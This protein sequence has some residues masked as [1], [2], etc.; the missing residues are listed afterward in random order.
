METP[1]SKDNNER[2]RRLIVGYWNYSQCDAEDMRINS[3]FQG[4]S[5]AFVR[6]LSGKSPWILREA[7]AVIRYLAAQL[8]IPFERVW[9]HLSDPHGSMWQLSQ[10]ELSSVWHP[11]LMAVDD[12]AYLMERNETTVECWRCFRRALPAWLMPVEMMKLYHRSLTAHLGKQARR[13]RQILNLY[14]H[15]RRDR[16]LSIRNTHRTAQVQIVMFMTDYYRMLF[17]NPPFDLC[18]THHIVECIESL[19]VDSLCGQDVLLG[20]I[21]EHRANAVPAELRPYFSLI[22]SAVAIGNDILILRNLN[23]TNRSIYKRPFGMLYDPYLDMHL[24]RLDGLF[25]IAEFRKSE[26]HMELIKDRLSLRGEW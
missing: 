12:L 9:D 19:L 16:F 24:D 5:P 4:S 7:E 10:L 6:R 2:I 26:V 1:F 13:V 17:R 23:S 21:D 15:L 18:G 8:S 22:E 20:F 11:S 14:G 25:S 3:G